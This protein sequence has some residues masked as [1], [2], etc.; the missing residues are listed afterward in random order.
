MSIFALLFEFQNYQQFLVIG[1]YAIL[2]SLWNYD[3]FSDKLKKNIKN[4]LNNN[5]VTLWVLGNAFRFLLMKWVLTE[6]LFWYLTS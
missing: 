1:T 6:I 5:S 4:Q 3:S 2:Q